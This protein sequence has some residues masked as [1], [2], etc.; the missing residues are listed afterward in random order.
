MHWK[1]GHFAAVV[2]ESE[3]LYEIEDPTFGENIRVSRRT[4]DEEGSGY[5][6]VPAGPLPKGWRVVSA[7]EGERIWGRGGTSFVDRLATALEDLLAFCLKSQ[8]GITTANVQTLVVGLALH[9]APL[10]YRTPKGPAVAFEL[11]YSH[12]DALQ[13]AIFT[14]T[15]FGPKWTSNWIS[16]LT[17]NR[18]TSGTIDLYAPGGGGETYSKNGSSFGPGL[19]DQAFVTPLG[20]GGFSRALPDGSTQTY[21]HPFGTNQFFL[22]SVS[23]PQGNT[24]TLTYDTHSR[25]TTITDA[26]GEK[27]TLTY[28]LASDIYKVT[29]VTDPF[30]RS[31]LFAYN[32]SGQLASITDSLGI[33]SSY[34]YLFGSGDFIST[35][36]TPYG[37]SRFTY[38]DS[39]TNYHLGTERFVTLTDPL[40][41]SQRVEFR[42]GAPGIPDTDPPNTLP[43][44]MLLTNNYLYYRNTFVWDKSQLQAATNPD[45]SVDYTKATIMHWLHRDNST[46][47]RILASI[48]QPLENRVWFDYAGSNSQF[49]GTSNQPTIIGRVL[50]DGTTQRSTFAYNSFGRVTKFI[51]PVGR[52]DTMVYAANGIDLLSIA[53]TTAGANQRLFSATYNGQ[54]E[55]LTATDA[56]GQVTHYTYNTAG[57]LLTVTNPLAQQTTLSYNTPG[58]LT[59]VQGPLAGA[60]IALTYDTAN[61]IASSTDELGYAQLFSY[62]VADRLTAVTYPDGT[63]N[64]YH[65][66]LLDL[67][68]VTDRPKRTS[69][70]IYDAI[71]RVTQ[72]TDPLGHSVQLAY[73]GCGAVSQITDENGHVTRFDHDL[74]SR[75]IGKTYADGTRTSYAYENTISRL[76]SLTD[77]LGQVTSYSYN[78][79]DTL[80]GIAYAHASNPTPAVSLAWDPPAVSLAWDPAFLRMLKMT[81]GTGATTYNYNPITNVPVLGAGR[82]SNIGG[83]RGDILSY[84]YD[85]LGRTVKTTADAAVLSSLTF[86]PI[87]RTTADNN[88]L[89]TFTINYLGASELPS[90]IASALS[91]KSSYSYF[92]NTGDDRLQKITNS[93]HAGAL[94]S[95]FQ[96]GYDAD[97]VVTSS[98]IQ[99][100]FAAAFTRNMTYDA[101]SRLLKVT[102]TAG[103]GSTFGFSYDPAGNR[104]SQTIG[105]AVTAFSYNKVDELIS[106]GPA[107]YD[108]E[109]QPLTL[110]GLSYKWDAAH[111]LVAVTGGTHTTTFAYDGQGGAC[112]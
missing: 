10:S 12:R 26:A 69:T 77:A 100:Q 56:S 40:G 48:K 49:Q 74:Q 13:P 55:P 47:S 112:A 97:G 57:Q 110:A 70:Y 106:P 20:S 78:I 67:A 94:V 72:T 93:N 111:R 8:G 102:P 50:D 18:T 68:S 107:T 34:A 1:V 104:T 5:F 25:L 32:S 91:L 19:L 99:K 29:R 9:D 17:D 92:P 109:G 24:V 62:D 33:T 79:D 81:D 4:L 14:Y 90:A 43:T 7:A 53:N 22:S 98:T 28:G 16:Y 30:G 31:A 82:L 21:T 58:L 6:V 37:V 44:G 88:A 86:D 27:T 76:S 61:R 46:A 65:Y 80:K 85:A 103:G 105:A 23:D 38:G 39:T 75:L 66:K 45:G 3:G 60:K 42:Q 54:H 95:S 2:G 71:R 73:C 52:Q 36:T 84:T 101:G 64:Q 96:Y 51:D 63:S 108:A 35:L 11:F 41:Q 87:G 59:G 83:P 15:N 89:D